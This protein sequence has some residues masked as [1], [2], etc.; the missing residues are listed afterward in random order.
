P[1]STRFLILLLSRHP[2][3]SPLFPP[4]RSSDLRVHPSVR[5]PRSPARLLREPRCQP[6]LHRPRPVAGVGGRQQPPGGTHRAHG[7]PRRGADRKSTRL[8]S[9]HVSISYAV[10][11]L[12]KQSENP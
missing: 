4:R 2:P 6:R 1:V 5:V 9:S 3:L 11:C 7:L 10:F 12:K 8:N